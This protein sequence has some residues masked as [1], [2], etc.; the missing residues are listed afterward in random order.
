[1]DGIK[2]VVDILNLLDVVVYSDVVLMKEHSE[3]CVPFVTI[4]KTYIDEHNVSSLVE[5][6]TMADDYAWI[7]TLIYLKKIKELEMSGQ[8]QH[9]FDDPVCYNIYTFADKL[10]YPMHMLSKCLLSRLHNWSLYLGFPSPRFLCRPTEL[11]IFARA[12]G[13]QRNFNKNNKKI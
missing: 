9:E 8:I 7:H 10:P 4:R 2:D 13:R 1:V 6:N 11:Y 3:H 12:V 5:A